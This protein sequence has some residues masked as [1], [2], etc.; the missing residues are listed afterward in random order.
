MKQEL[1]VVVHDGHGPP[2]L[3]VHGMLASRAQWLL[4]LPVL[5]TVTTP[6]S[7]ELWGHHDS[8]SPSDPEAYKPANYS[9][10]FEAIRERLGVDRWFVGGCSL[11]GALTMRYSLDNPDRVIGQFLTNS[12][13]AFADEDTSKKWQEN[14]ASSYER[15]LQ[16]GMKAVARIPVH[17]RHATRLPEN[18]KEALLQDGESHDVKGIAST[19][20]WTS[21][22]ASVR[23]HVAQSSVPTMLICGSFEKR[24]RPLREYVILNMPG[25]VVHDLPAGHAVNMEA[26]DGFNKH[27]AAFIREHME[28]PVHG[29]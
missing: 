6:V 5:S 4:N 9:R 12:S 24:F 29:A 16:G 20:R 28:E 27:V 21:P 7:V 2:L 10:M 15:V 19:M 14:S 11:G 23:Q 1:S 13:S 22:F 26:A 25:L 17:P 18:V 3:L 8:P